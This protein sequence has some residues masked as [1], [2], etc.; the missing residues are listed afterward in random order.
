MRYELKL[1]RLTFGI[2][3]FMLVGFVVFLLRIRP[4][5]AD[6]R[7]EVIA[8]LAIVILA[9]AVFTMM[10]IIEGA[11]AFEFGKKHKRELLA[12]GLY[13]AFSEEASLQ[14]VSL[15]A[16]PHALLFG[17][18]ELRIAQHLERHPLYRRGLRLSGLIEIALGIALVVG[19]GKSNE[20]VA[21]L[22]G[23]VAI[24]SILQLLPML[25]YSHKVVSRESSE[26]L[27]T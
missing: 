25:F 26:E 11:I 13:L 24:L 15:V 17:L 22:L 20:G 21:M 16:A 2:L 10:G 5:L 14:I 27:H 3:T 18:G 23:Y 9:A 7:L 19:S 4:S 1:H 12:S 8:S 6:E